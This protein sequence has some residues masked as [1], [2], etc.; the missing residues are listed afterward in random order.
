[1]IGMDDRIA[2]FSSL[3]NDF[4][5][6]ARADDPAAG[7]GIDDTSVSAETYATASEQGNQDDSGSAATTPA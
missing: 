7:A 6:A 5:D 2:Q 1:M 4:Y 3:M